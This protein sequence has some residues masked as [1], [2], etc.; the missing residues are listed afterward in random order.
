MTTDT[1][2][3]WD[4]D[5]KVHEH[6]YLTDLLGER[7]IASID[8]YAKAKQT[9]PAEPALQCAALALGRPGG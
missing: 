4:Q 6:G 5:V 7:A 9:V 1:D 2:D 3:L 8:A